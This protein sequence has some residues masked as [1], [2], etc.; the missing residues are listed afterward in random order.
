MKNKL[1]IIAL[2]DLHGLL[3]EITQSADIAIIAGDIIPLELQKNLEHSKWWFENEFAAWIDSIPV[4]KVFF[5]AGNH[6]FYLET[7]KKQELSNLYKITKKKLKYLMNENTVYTDEYGVSWSIFGTPYCSQFFEWPF[8]RKDSILTTKYK[9]IPKKVDIII[10][11][12]AP[13]ACGDADVILAKP[14]LGHIG[15][16]PLA[17]RIMETDYKILICGHIHTGDHSFNEEYRTINVSIL[18]EKYKQGY[19]PTYITIEK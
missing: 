14:Q 2:S 15:N 12:D 5:I 17:E 3:P 9:K 8:M 7:I 6:D 16:K 10:S 13:F 11:H 1:K 4:K 18:N 19:D